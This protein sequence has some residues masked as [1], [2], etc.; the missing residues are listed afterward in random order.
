MKNK[1]TVIAFLL[2]GGLNSIISQTYNHYFGNIHA[3]SS[4]SDGNKDSAAS[5]LTKPWQDF[6]VAKNAQHIDF[7]GI[8]EHNHFSAGMLSPAYYHRGL[9]DADSMNIDG[10]FVAM[11]G[12]EWGT[13]SGGGHVIIYGYDS[14]LGWDSNDYDV[15]VPQNDYTALWKKINE[16]PSSFAYLAHPQTSDYES[17]FSTTA[18]I[19]ADNAIIGLAARSGPAFS[20]NTTY[21]DPS[22]GSFINRYNDA[23]KR[24]Y[25]VGV[26]LDHD[27]HNS[28]FGEQSA[29]RLVVLAPS[30]TRANVM[31]ALKKMRFYS[32][33]D[34]NAKVN[35]T[36]SGQPMGSSLIQSGACTLVA[37]VTDADGE[38][39]SSIVVYY[40]VPGA[41]T[42]P[43]VLTTVNAST[44][45]YTHNLANNSSYYYYLKITQADGNI[46]WTSPIWYTRNN[47]L[48]NTP[49]VAA[50]S[51][52]SNIVCVGQEVDLIDNS[53][54]GPTSWAWSAPGA[55][56]SSP[57]FQ[58]SAVTYYAP[59]TYTVHLTASNASGSN[60]A[61][62]K[63]ITVNAYPNLTVSSINN[64][65]GAPDSLVAQ[66]A[67]SY[68]WS[69]GATTSTIYFPVPTIS[70]TYSVTGTSN[71]CSVTAATFVIAHNCTGIS[72]QIEGAL[73]I[74][75]NPVNHYLTVDL[76]GL[77]E[78]KTIE[79]YN[80]LGEKVFE[81]SY[82]ESLIK[83]DISKFED[84]IYMIKIVIENK[85]F[86]AKN[87]LIEKTH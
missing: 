22:T 86:G 37:N 35:F 5:L 25:H 80:L 67:N 54:N 20:T 42:A 4:Y 84:G 78:E 31:D 72:D 48:T 60:V 50:F 2:L 12:M 56:P 77:N 82:Q 1:I 76:A 13:I 58:N 70:T 57:T 32:S 26:G 68:L 61:L 45:S 15:L 30:L 18:N 14:L 23:L 63:T 28:V 3:H 34:W 59:G 16:T 41:G 62:T 64:C 10:S 73:T 38:S 21:S 87:F 29:G 83:L 74:Y 8:S 51:L 17:L 19:S 9:H 79:I 49:P 65:P 43:A 11:Y 47:S 71:G 27:T 46:I 24:G 69:N 55:S 75:P 85:I 40:G 81:K 44:L 39:V 52:S 53:T 6:N 66:G 7:Y 33:D 36:I